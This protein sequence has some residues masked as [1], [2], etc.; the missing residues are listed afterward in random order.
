MEDVDGWVSCVR[1]LSRNHNDSAQDP[2][3]WACNKYPSKLNISNS[4]K[5]RDKYRVPKGVR[6]IFSNQLD[7]PYSPPNGYMTVMS[8]AFEC[9]MRLPLHLFSEPYS[10]VTMYVF[11]SC[12]QTSGLSQ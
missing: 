8:D 2:S 10:K 3:Y 11:L 6:L 5:I 7:K 9:G 12:L 4:I 1:E